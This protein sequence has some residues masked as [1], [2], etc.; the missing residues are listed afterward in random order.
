MF[1]FP[2]CFQLVVAKTSNIARMAQR[3]AKLVNAEAENTEDPEF[4]AKLEQMSRNIQDGKT[5]NIQLSL[6]KPC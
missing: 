2:F 3:I 5:K 1:V 4:R 6:M